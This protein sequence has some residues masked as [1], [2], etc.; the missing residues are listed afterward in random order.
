MSFDKRQFVK[1]NDYAFVFK[2]FITDQHADEMQKIA[3]TNHFIVRESHP[4]QEISG[5]P[6]GRVHEMISRLLEKGT[7]CSNLS[8][9]NTPKGLFWGE[10]TDLEDYNKPYQ[11]KTH[12]GIVYLNNFEG[13][14]VYY[15][16]SNTS[17][18]PNRGDLLIHESDK[19]HGVTEVKSDGRY[20]INFHLWVKNVI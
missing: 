10:H 14:D 3:K 19:L 6:D 16:E 20:T 12:G 17:Y 5:Y 7:F 15:S 2:N 18:H 4:I 1:I 11:K 9:V 13:G 8:F